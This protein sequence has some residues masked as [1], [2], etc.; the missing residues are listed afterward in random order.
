MARS[1]ASRILRLGRLDAPASVPP[2]TR[3]PPPWSLPLG[4]HRGKVSLFQ[5]WEVPSFN[6]TDWLRLDGQISGQRGRLAFR[7]VPVLHKRAVRPADTRSPRRRPVFQPHR[8]LGERRASDGIPCARETAEPSHRVSERDRA[9]R[10]IRFRATETF[11]RSPTGVRSAGDGIQVSRSL[12][13]RL[14]FNGSASL[15]VAL[16]SRLT[17]KG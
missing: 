2:L 10:G 14:Q 12:A 13:R 4:F 3:P 15:R 16:S 9:R 17:R 8:A 1:V 11:Q 6:E 5:L 7:H